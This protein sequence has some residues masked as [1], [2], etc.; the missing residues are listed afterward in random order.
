MT[1]YCFNIFL[2]G[3]REEIFKNNKKYKK[4]WKLIKKQDTKSDDEI[5]EKNK[6]ERHFLADHI[7]KYFGIL[8]LIENAE[9]KFFSFT[10]LIL[11]KDASPERVH[12]KFI[13]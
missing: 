9:G 13:A 3:K 2:Q 11:S 8:E 6:F 4:I 10:L 7:K 1:Y 5:K 12:L